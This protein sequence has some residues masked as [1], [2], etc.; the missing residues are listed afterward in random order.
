MEKYDFRDW[1]RMKKKEN[2]DALHNVEIDFGQFSGRTIDKVPLPYLKWMVRNHVDIKWKRL[3]ELELDRRH[4]GVDEHFFT[5]HAIERF[6]Q[7]C[8][9]WW[10]ERGD[11]GI[12][13][14]MRKLFKEAL[15]NGIRTEAAPPAMAV[16]DVGIKW[17]YEIS[18]SRKGPIY[19]ICSVVAIGHASSFGG[20]H[21]RT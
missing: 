3:A 21:G 7:R 20:E 5:E 18:E 15:V 12:I 14:C 11:T 16:T 9:S 13:S 4:V 17:I 19:T 8:R 6:S 2:E 10:K 1:Q